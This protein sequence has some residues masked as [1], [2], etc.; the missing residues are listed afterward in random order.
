LEQARLFK[1]LKQHQPDDDDPKD[2]NDY[3]EDHNSFE[4]DDDD[5]EEDVGARWLCVIHRQA[6]VL[7]HVV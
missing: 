1:K 3:E 5:D 4:E 2:D 7:H 6:K